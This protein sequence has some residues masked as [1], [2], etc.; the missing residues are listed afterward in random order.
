[1]WF[2]ALDAR[3]I[4]GSISARRIGPCHIEQAGAYHAL[5]EIADK[6]NVPIGVE[7]VRPEKEP[8]IIIDFP[9]GT[10]ADL[11]NAFVAKAPDYAWTETGKGIVH[12][13]R[14]KGHI[15]LLDVAMSYPGAD[16]KTRQQIWED[17]AKRPEISAWTNSAR[18]SRREYFQGQE[19]KSNN[20]PV[21][22]APGYLTLEQLLDEVT[23][24]S[25]DN[26]W[27]VLQSPPSAGPC[28]VAIILW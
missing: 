18:C 23:I 13:S 24:K 26:Y 28:E 19:F 22:I 16:N 12:V 4:D 15:A 10:I 2:G 20:G 14:S 1:M 11:L 9:G 7:A 5:A 8:T 21:S 6:A 17:L 25:G 3:A 27:A